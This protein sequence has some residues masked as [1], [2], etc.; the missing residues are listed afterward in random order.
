[1]EYIQKNYPQLVP[2]Y[3]EIYDC[4]DYSY[5]KSLDKELQAYAAE[6]G[7]DYVIN[8]D[9][10][11]RPFDAFPLLVN[12]FYHEKIKKKPKQI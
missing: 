3:H 7:L 9:S 11:T 8:D 5:W 12:F 1:M 4:K 6:I 10:M 2:L